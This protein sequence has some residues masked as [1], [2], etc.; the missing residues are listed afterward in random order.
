MTTPKATAKASLKRKNQDQCKPDATMTSK[1]KNQRTNPDNVGGKKRPADECSLG[2]DAA[3]PD[4]MKVSM[5]ADD[6]LPEAD[7]VTMDFFEK[8]FAGLKYLEPPLSDSAFKQYL[9]DVST[10]LT[11][12]NVEIRTKRRSCLRR[13]GRENDP[14][15]KALVAFSENVASFHQLVKCYLG[16]TSSSFFLGLGTIQT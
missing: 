5:D 15:H 16:K 2:M 11:Q 10:Q 6:D 14:L 13:S 7:R 4:D 12:M 1:P 9:Q 3:G 8:K